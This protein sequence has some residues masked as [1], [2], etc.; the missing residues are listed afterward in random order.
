MPGL[1]G[2]GIARPVIV[3]QNRAGIMSGAVFGTASDPTPEATQGS[4]PGPAGYREHF[5]SF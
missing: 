1:T 4:A 3:R 2:I 5:I